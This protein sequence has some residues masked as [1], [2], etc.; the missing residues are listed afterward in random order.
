MVTLESE[1]P[2][3]DDALAESIR[4]FIVSYPDLHIVLK[5]KSPARFVIANKNCKLVGHHHW[6]DDCN[7]DV[8][9][10]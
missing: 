6:W 7:E 2:F 4:E 3:E 9:M 5:H 10:S 1:E 8:F